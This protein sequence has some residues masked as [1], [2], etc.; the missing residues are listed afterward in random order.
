MSSYA[1]H[2]HER[3]EGREGH[4]AGAVG[5][6]IWVAL[7]N[8]ADLEAF[9]ANAA[10]PFVA[11]RRLG[12]EIGNCSRNCLKAR[13]KSVRQ[14]ADRNLRVELLPL[15]RPIGELNPSAR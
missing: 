7:P 8:H 15:R 13:A 9:G 12:R 3:R 11:Q 6:R 4:G 5:L 2:L 14:T 1:C 10:S